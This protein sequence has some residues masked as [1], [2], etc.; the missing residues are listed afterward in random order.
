MSSH[1]QLADEV[2]QKI[3][4]KEK[5]KLK[6]KTQNPKAC[7][8]FSLIEMLVATAIFS[9]VMTL[10][11]G[12][13]LAIIDGNNKA[14]GLKLA[15]NNIN[16]AVEGMSR[17]IKIGTRYRCKVGKKISPN[18]PPFGIIQ[19]PKDCIGG[20]TL[21]AFEKFGGDSSDPG[22]QTVYRFVEDSTSPNARGWIER[23][24]SSCYKSG[25]GQ[26][27]P[28]TAP[29]IDVDKMTFYV[30]G[31][32]SVDLLQPRVVLIVSGTAGDTER[33]RTHFNVQTTLSQ[34]V[35]DIP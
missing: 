3:M 19:S 22:D 12:S 26:Y 31:A 29:E 2:A 23:C 18:P 27:I 35:L 25:I 5:L 32:E 6:P 8:G 1:R 20:G 9:V 24:T 17:T 13:L 15:M 4:N 21:F 7:G 10:S 14:Q 16:F 34:R 33:S 11:V 28:I 30:E